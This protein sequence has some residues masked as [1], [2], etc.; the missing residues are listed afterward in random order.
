MTES[1]DSWPGWLRDWRWTDLAKGLWVGLVRY[2]RD[3]L[4]HEHA[5]SGELLNVEPE[6]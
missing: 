5:D 4:T 6:E 2:E 3:G 1:A